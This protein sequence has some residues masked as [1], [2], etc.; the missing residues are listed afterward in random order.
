[1]VKELEISKITIRIIIIVG[2][3]VGVGL[4]YNLNSPSGIPIIN[5]YSV[6][7]VDGQKNKIPVFLISQ[8]TDSDQ[9][10]FHP[11]EQIGLKQTYQ[12]FFKSQA[13]F[14]DARSKDKYK[15]GHIPGAISIPV[16]NI[17]PDKINLQNIS[18]TQ[19]IIVYCDDPQCGLSMELAAI[20]EKKDF[21]DVYFFSGGW[22]AWKNANYQTSAGMKP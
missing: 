17:Q 16:N 6:I 12:S 8:N 2:I 20:L 5:N 18:P 7:D 9:F 21:L 3:A 22:E 19:K 15:K 14:I 1:M 10:E 13:I 4:L 11:P